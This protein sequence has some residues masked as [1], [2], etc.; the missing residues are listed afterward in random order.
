MATKCDL[1][2]LLYV[3]GDPEDERTHEDRHRHFLEPIQP[4][5]SKALK[6]HLDG[7][8]DAVWV[9]FM[10]PTWLREEVYWRAKVFQREFGYD[11]PQWEQNGYHDPDA[12]GFVFHDVELRIS[13]ACCFRP[14]LSNTGQTRLDWIWLCPSARRCG[15]VSSQWK[16]FR[17][18]F[19]VFSIEGPISK[20]MQAFLLKHYPDHEIPK[21]SIH[22]PKLPMEL[23]SDVVTRTRS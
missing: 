20:A 12:V 13:G 6:D 8:P 21:P 1:C 19:G 16:R 5:P 23:F 7:H 11:M 18:R 4:S 10:S 2:G 22:E 14:E 9:D 17:D 3:D 15:L